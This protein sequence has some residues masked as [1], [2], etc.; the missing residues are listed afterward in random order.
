ML[1]LIYP[2]YGVIFL[3]RE[4]WYFYIPYLDLNF[5]SWRFFLV[6]C[7][8][9]SILS[10]IGMIAFIPESPKF[11]YAQGDESQTLKILQRI[12]VCNTGKNVDE[13][14]VR[15][16]IKD[17]EF[18]HKTDEKTKGFLHFMWSQTVPL[19]KSP[20]LKNTLTAC[21]L[22]FGVCLSS[23]GFWTFLTET[24]NRVSL[25]MEME[26]EHI[27]P[28]LCHIVTSFDSKNTTSSSENDAQIH[29]VTKLELGTF[30]NLSILL[31]AYT[32]SLLVISL[33][34]KKVGKIIIIT[35]IMFTCGLASVLLIFVNI[36]Y[37]SLALYFLMLLSIVNLSVIN[38]STVE[39]FPTSL[40]YSMRI[41]RCT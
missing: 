23:N 39:L 19:F 8:M 15:S 17:E 24:L 38:A 25:W 41:L 27:D 21:Y 2:I 14:E 40:R 5:S 30:T 36:P 26:P 1:L 31:V 10:A 4:S 35:S 20:N 3:N 32:L 11:V 12:F 37:V 16:L 28:T 18:K 22:Q 13:Y 33:L 7:G 34:I 9:P 29:C 6:I